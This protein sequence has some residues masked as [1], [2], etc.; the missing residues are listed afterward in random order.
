MLPVGKSLADQTL[1]SNYVDY[2]ESV[3]SLIDNGGSAPV[4]L[5][6][7]IFSS[8]AQFE[9]AS[10]QQPAVPFTIKNTWYNCNTITVRWESNQSPEPV[11]GI[12]VLHAV[13][14]PLQTIGGPTLWQI[15]EVW[16]EFDSATWLVNLGVFKPASKEKK[17]EIA[18]KA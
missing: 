15:D 2:S 8:R 17:R 16:A 6:S 9:S 18:F 1:A 11:V 14:A 10:S 5:L 13:F 3:N 7:A 4:G 12:S